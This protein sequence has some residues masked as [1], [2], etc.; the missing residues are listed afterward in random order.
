MVCADRSVRQHSWL[1][2]SAARL[3][4][5]PDEQYIAESK[6][7]RAYRFIISV[8]VNDSTRLN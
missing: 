6:T 7:Y 5:P 8:C 4:K 1:G 2:Q 3:H